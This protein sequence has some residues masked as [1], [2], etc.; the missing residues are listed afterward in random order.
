M[1]NYLGGSN[2]N[3]DEVEALSLSKNEEHGQLSID[4]SKIKFP[5]FEVN[6]GLSSRAISLRRKLAQKIKSFQI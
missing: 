2:F 1:D 5:P 6:D 4:Y 3:G